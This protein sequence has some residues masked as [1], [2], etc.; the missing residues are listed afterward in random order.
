MGAGGEGLGR[1]GPALRL[2]NFPPEAGPPSGLNLGPDVSKMRPVLGH[3]QPEAAC[4]SPGSARRTRA[5]LEG[6]QRRHEAEGR[7][8]PQPSQQHA[9][10]RLRGVPGPLPRLGHPVPLAPRWAHWSPLNRHS[11]LHVGSE[12]CTRVPRAVPATGAQRSPTHGLS[13]RVN[14]EYPPSGTRDRRS[15]LEMPPELRWQRGGWRERSR[16][17]GGMEWTGNWGVYFIPDTKDLM[18]MHPTQLPEQTG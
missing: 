4:L 1:S 7:L 11:S 9:F 13:R 16:C 17:T 5:G 12:R 15:T 6:Q 14:T 2:T 3:P 18:Q 10:L 8:G